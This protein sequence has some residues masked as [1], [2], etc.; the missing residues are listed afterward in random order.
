MIQQ[1]LKP[2]LFDRL[3]SYARKWMKNWLSVLRALHMTPSWA[4]GHMPFSLVYGSEAILP[5][6]VEQR[7]FRVQQ[8][9][10]EQSNDFRVDDLTKLEELCEAAVIQLAKHQQT[11]R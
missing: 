10:E 1:G 11:M 7:S 8:Y 9:S 3:K 6:K 5:T 2:R 4:T